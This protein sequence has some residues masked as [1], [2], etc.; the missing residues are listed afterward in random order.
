MYLKCECGEVL[1]DVAAP[2]DIEHL[3]LSYRAQERLENLA[4]AEVR[5]EGEIRIW[6]EL[7]EQAGAIVVWRCPNCGR[8][9]L[10][11]RGP[12]SDV[13]VYRFEKKGLD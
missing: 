13:L 1:T 11:A 4:D 10:N 5:Q 12:A 8:L 3:L 6:P 2:N 7:W 9:Y